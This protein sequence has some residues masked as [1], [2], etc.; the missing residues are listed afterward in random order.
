MAILTI[1]IGMS[2]FYRINQVYPWAIGLVLLR[3]A[4]D[5]IAGLQMR[6]AGYLDRGAALLNGLWLWA[7][8]IGLFTVLWWVQSHYQLWFAQHRLCGRT[9]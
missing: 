4:Y 3:M 6:R 2:L 1:S 7:A 5:V 8:I 9:C